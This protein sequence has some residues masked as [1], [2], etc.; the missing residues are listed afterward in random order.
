[1][2]HHPPCPRLVIFAHSYSQ[3]V[4]ADSREGKGWGG[5][6]KCK[7]VTEITCGA[8]HWGAGQIVVEGSPQCSIQGKGCTLLC[9]GFL[10]FRTSSLLHSEDHFCPTRNHEW[11]DGRSGGRLEVQKAHLLQALPAC[12]LFDIIN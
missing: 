9:L 2:C 5:W 7:L 6:R 12:N 8:Q 11:G 1:M 4:K 10:L 3:G